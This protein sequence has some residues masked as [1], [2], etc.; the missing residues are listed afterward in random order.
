MYTFSRGHGEFFPNSPVC[1]ARGSGHVQRAPGNPQYL[2]SG[3]F[4]AWTNFGVF[5]FTVSRE[6]VPA[7]AVSTRPTQVE[8][9]QIFSAGYEYRAPSPISSTDF[10]SDNNAYFVAAAVQGSRSV[11]RGVGGGLNDN[12]RYGTDVSPKLSIGGYLLPFRPGGVLGQVSA[13]QARASRI[14]T[15]PSCFPRRSAMESGSASGAGAH[16]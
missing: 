1:A 16:G 8:E 2:G 4:V 13:L 9:D 15:F 7:S 10:R 14:R 3:E 11:V 6:S 5:D 12:S